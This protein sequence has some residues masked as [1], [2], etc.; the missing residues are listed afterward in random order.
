MVLIE[1]KRLWRKKVGKLNGARPQRSLSAWL[2]LGDARHIKHMAMVLHIPP[3]NQHLPS[4]PCTMA[5]MKSKYTEV[6]KIV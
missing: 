4:S 5:V 1:K 3:L 2:L 6:E